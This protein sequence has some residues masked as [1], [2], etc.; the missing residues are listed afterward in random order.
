MLQESTNTFA[1]MMASQVQVTVELGNKLTHYL[2]DS[3][4]ETTDPLCWWLA[5]RQLYPNLA[6]MAI[7][8][9]L[10][11][12]YALIFLCFSYLFYLR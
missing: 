5:N 2:L 7:N 9:Q 4:V 12:W 6:Q 3:C 11:T 1:A 10:D 8:F